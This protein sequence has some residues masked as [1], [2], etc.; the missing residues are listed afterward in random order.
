MNIETVDIYDLKSGCEDHTKYH[1]RLS[2]SPK[3]SWWLSGQRRFG[4]L[5]RSGSYQN[6]HR[7]HTGRRSTYLRKAAVRL[8]GKNPSDIAEIHNLL[9]GTP[10]R[11]NEQ[12]DR[13]KRHRRSLLRHTRQVGKKAN[14]PALGREHQHPW[15]LRLLVLESKPL[16]NW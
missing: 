3:I 4:G 16:K 12:P 6:H 2:T 15:F 9:E 1:S 10:G 5:R 13:Q 11:P 7:R 8:K 14:L